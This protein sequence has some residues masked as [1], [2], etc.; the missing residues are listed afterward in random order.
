M[1][2]IARVGVKYSPLNT[3]TY[4]P[5]MLGGHQNQQSGQIKRGSMPAR[6]QWSS[7]RG[8]Q[9]EDEVDGLLQS[10]HLG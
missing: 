7:R 6:K 9:M 1:W 8:V 3:P 5:K 10:E 2:D 4:K